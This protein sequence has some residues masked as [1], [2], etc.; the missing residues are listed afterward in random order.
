MSKV[1]ESSAGGDTHIRSNE[2][3]AFI[4]ATKSGTQYNI[5]K[6]DGNG[7]RDITRTPNVTK[8]R[9]HTYIG[10]RMEKLKDSSMIYPA[11]RKMLRGRLKSDARVGVPLH[12]AIE[13]EDRLLVSETIERIEITAKD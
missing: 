2:P 6:P 3:V 4:V 11:D 5:G 9:S 1:P 8:K 13:E 7:I 12:I 10:F